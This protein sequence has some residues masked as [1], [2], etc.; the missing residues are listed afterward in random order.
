MWD[1]DLQGAQ[2]SAGGKF[3]SR[4]KKL[5]HR[6]MEGHPEKQMVLEH[7]RYGAFGATSQEHHSG[8]GI[9]GPQDDESFLDE[10]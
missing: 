2:A 6:D 9:R 7:V 10:I 1:C 4:R 3:S 5:E 8:G